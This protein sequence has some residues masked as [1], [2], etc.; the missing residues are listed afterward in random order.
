MFKFSLFYLF[1][2]IGSLCF[3]Q[4]NYIALIT[5]PQIGTQE[6]A[7]NLIKVV[8][9]INIRNNISQVIV[10][11][12]ITANGKFDEFI[13][14]QE[15]LDALKV[16]Y[17]VVGGEKDYLLSE[18]KG[19]EISSLWGDD[20][21]IFYNKNINL[22]CFN[23]ILPEYS[24]DNH[25]SAETLNWL[26]DIFVKSNS[27][28]IITF[29][30]LPLSK[31]D[32]SSNFFKITLDYK[33]FSFVSK[34]EKQRSEIP[35]F[36]GFYLNRKNDWGYLLISTKKDSV[37][38]KKILG[39]ELKKKTKPEI[40][41]SSFAPITLFKSIKPVQTFS[42]ADVLWEADLEKTIV[43]SPV[44]KGDKILAAFKDG[45][46]VCISSEGNEKWRYES[47]GKIKSS[48]KTSDDLLIVSTTEGDIS[49]L[50]INTGP[51]A[52]VIG[53]GEKLAG[54]AVADLERNSKGIVAG[55]TNGN[56]YC[57]NLATLEQVWTNQISD[58]AIIPP[59]VYS[60]S[61]IFFQDKKGTLYCISVNNGLLI[62]KI[63]AKQGEWK[64]KSSNFENNIIAVS[65]NLFLIDETGNLFCVDA[66]LGMNNWNIKNI[67]AG[68]I[69]QLNDKNDLTVSTNKNKILTISI[70]SKK[71][72]NE[73]VLPQ[74]VNT[75][76]DFCVIGNNVLVSYDDGIVYLIKPKQ[77][78]EKIF[79]GSSAPVVSLTNINGNCLI[80]DYD[81]N[82]I[83]LKIL[84]S[85]K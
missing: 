75:M 24:T 69:I 3:A 6:A 38:I 43:T 30:Y 54:I 47:H 81:G 61:K 79:R 49:T 12:N 53:I 33:L 17:F 56:L 27:K 63:S 85:K 13:W 60:K 64:N 44:T 15:I 16:P 7:D 78:P 14:A 37:I 41:K 67:E 45:T 21:K 65:N 82:F 18:G 36:E 57:Y 84:P 5:E 25:L 35:T 32:N 59:V 83:L 11:G 62:W 73:I 77:K 9:D 22:V 76:T 2:I 26:K 68:G 55:T 20:K 52:Q 42:S 10:L 46:I 74:V 72:I 58:V 28:R 8:E 29:S 19:S 70:K 71:I 31:S 51:P 39:D 4:S 40:I 34:E 66:L 80:T 48:I 1:I 50:D 23:T